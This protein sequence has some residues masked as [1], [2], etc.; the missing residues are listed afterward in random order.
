MTETYNVCWFCKQSISAWDLQTQEAVEVCFVNEA[1]FYV[2]K[3]C[4]SKYVREHIVKEETNEK[5]D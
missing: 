1:Y 2:H 5:V 4:C 3:Q